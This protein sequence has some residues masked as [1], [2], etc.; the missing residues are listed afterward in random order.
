[1]AAAAGVLALVI[2]VMPDLQLPLLH[3]AIFFLVSVAVQGIYN[4]LTLYLVEL[5]PEAELTYFIAVGNTAWGAAGIFVALAFGTLAHIQHAA[6]PIMCIVGLYIAAC[7]YTLRLEP[8]RGA[9]A[10]L[11]KPPAT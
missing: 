3:S 2:Q 5:A 1:M 9:E 6:W 11:P 4:A 10:P 8:V 7:L